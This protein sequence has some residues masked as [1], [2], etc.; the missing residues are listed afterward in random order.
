M[1]F[2]A[3]WWPPHPR[4]SWASGPQRCHRE[5]S[6]NKEISH[7]IRNL[8]FRFRHRERLPQHGVEHSAGL[9]KNRREANPP[10]T[11]LRVRPP[12]RKNQGT[13]RN[14]TYPSRKLRRLRKKTTSMET[15]PVMPAAM[16][17][18]AGTRA[19][20][21]RVTPKLWQASPVWDAPPSVLPMRPLPLHLQRIRE[22]GSAAT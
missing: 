21:S 20:V 6:A 3:S 2:W 13:S 11:P 15:T 16:A 8:V 4:R 17:L 12:R 9:G 7:A 10:S 19:A 18:L 22:S 1:I 5:T 14:L